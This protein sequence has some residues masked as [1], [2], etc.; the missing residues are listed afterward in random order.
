LRKDENN[1]NSIFSSIINIKHIKEITLSDNQLEVD[2]Q[3]FENPNLDKILEH[4]KKSIERDTLLSITEKNK[5]NDESKAMHMKG[6]AIYEKLSK[7]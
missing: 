5:E 7:M 4:E 1:V 2:F 6:Y 3:E